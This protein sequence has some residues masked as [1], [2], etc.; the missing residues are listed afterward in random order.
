MGL[1]RCEAILME[2]VEGPETAEQREEEARL[3]GVSI[4]LTKYIEALK[5]TGRSS[6]STSTLPGTSSLVI[7]VS[8]SFWDVPPSMEPFLTTGE[9]CGFLLAWDFTYSQDLIQ[10]F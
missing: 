8:V 2:E 5:N 1:M 10:F 3:G 6:G 9:E 7:L 4:Q